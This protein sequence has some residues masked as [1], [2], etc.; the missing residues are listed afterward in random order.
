MARPHK[1]SS[2]RRYH[3]TYNSNHTITVNFKFFCPY[4]EQETTSRCEANA[5]I[6]ELFE[7]GG[8]FETLRC[9]LCGKATDVTFFPYAKK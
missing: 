3:I 5:D 8:Y 2:A 4:C 9:D 6:A 7:R 1:Q